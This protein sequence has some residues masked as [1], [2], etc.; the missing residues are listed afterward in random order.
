[1]PIPGMAEPLLHDLGMRVFNEKQ[2]CSR[3]TEIVEA[4]ARHV[5]AKT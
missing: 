4:N 1:M 3:V 5:R 2:R